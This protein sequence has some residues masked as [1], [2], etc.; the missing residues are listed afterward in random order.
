M[1]LNIP[2]T[3]IQG[4]RPPTIQTRHAPKLHPQAPSPL[5]RRPHSSLRLPQPNQHLRETHRKSLRLGLSRW[6]RWPPRATT[7]IRYPV[8]SIQAYIPRRGPR[9][10]AG[11]YPC[12]AAVAAGHDVETIHEPGDT[13]WRKG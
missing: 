3:L 12:H 2:L 6:R 8:Q 11:G 4:L 5:L 13:I 7:H 10:P 9:N 1:K